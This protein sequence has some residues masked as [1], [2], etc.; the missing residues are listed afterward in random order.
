LSDLT[1]TKGKVKIFGVTIA[2]LNTFAFTL[3]ATVD[4]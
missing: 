1:S 4:G 3:T 2:D